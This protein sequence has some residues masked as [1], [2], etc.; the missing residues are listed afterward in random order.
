MTGKNLAQLM[1]SAENAPGEAGGKRESHIPKIDAPA[2]VKA[3]E[4]FLV[5]VTVGPH[6]N[7]NEH[8]IRWVS[9]FIEEDGRAFNPIMLAKSSFAPGFASPEVVFKVQLQKGGTLHA[10]EYC[11]MHGLWTGMKDIKIA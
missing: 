3:G 4:A 6:P 7:T 2:S 10:S 5:K 1:Y 9:L 11:N 8:S